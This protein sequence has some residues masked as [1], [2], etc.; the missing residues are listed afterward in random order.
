MNGIGT[1]TC[2]RD[3]VNARENLFRNALSLLLSRGFRTVTIRCEKSHLSRSIPS[4]IFLA[5]PPAFA[6]RMKTRFSTAEQR[7]AIGTWI[8]SHSNR[9]ASLTRLDTQSSR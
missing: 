9:S 1:H 5:L 4:S 3:G 8:V 2:R 6:C 7:P